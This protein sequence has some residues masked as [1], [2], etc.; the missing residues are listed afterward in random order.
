MTDPAPEFSRIARLDE[1]GRIDWP[2]QVEA[3]KPERDALARRFGLSELKFLAASYS[4]DRDGA[5]IMAAG[6]IEAAL[7]QPCVA[8]GE[9]VEETVQEDFA[10]RFLP[11]SSASAADPADEIEIDA[12]G[13]DILP[14]SGERIDM[15]EAIAET[16]A[17]A[18]NPYPRSEKADAFLREAGVLTEEQVGPFAALANLGKKQGS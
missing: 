5:A 1:I 15:G 9:P 11:E 6:T 12:E 2:L 14:Y 16:L 10:I 4:L 18:I 17:L 3:S 7:S 8:T 13:W